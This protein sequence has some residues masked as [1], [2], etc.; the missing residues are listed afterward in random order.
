MT[1]PDPAAVANLPIVRLRQG[2]RLAVNDQLAVEE[3]LE[4]RLG[5]TDSRQGR[6][7]KSIAITMRTPGDDI[8]LALG[9]LFAER[10]IRRM[11]EV[12]SIDAGKANVLR[13]ELRDDV[14][15]DRLRLDR[16]FYTTSSCG[17]CG[18]ASLET[19]SLAGFD[20]L[21]DNH[22]T[23]RLDTLRALPDRLREQQP[24]FALTGGNHGVALFNAFGEILLVREDV[25]RHNA[26]DKLVGT[27]LQ[28][29]R[30]PLQD[31]GLL[32]SGR[33]SFEMMQKALA[34]GCPLVAAVG[35]PS[36]LA[37]ELAQEFNLTLAGFVGERDCN[38]YHGSERI[39][40]IH[41][42]EALQY[43]PKQME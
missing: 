7:H 30:L 24:L 8:A 11:D 13:I 40:P 38:I 1:T 10:I 35:A 12:S 23:L 15:V 31:C 39:L 18:K 33:A 19:L 21:Q 26:M 2:Q 22:F 6:V 16:N 32:L 25:G 5:Y 17:M 9:F 3:P 29:Q 43:R 20:A 36:S 42:A 41:L 28:Q 27:L 14:A 34:A 37:V 4:I